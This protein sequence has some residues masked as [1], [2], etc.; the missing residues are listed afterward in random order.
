M[1]AQRFVVGPDGQADDVPAGYR[2]E[3]VPD[4]GWK[5]ADLD[6]TCRHRG[7]NDPAMAALRRKHGR[8]FRWWYYCGAHLYGRKIEDGMVKVERLVEIAA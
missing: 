8:G 2:R 3:W 7:C 5:L 1:N 4:E 6:R